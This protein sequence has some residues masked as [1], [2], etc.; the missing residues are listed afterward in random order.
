VG[1]GTDVLAVHNLAD[2]RA[3][4]RVAAP[5]EGPWRCVWSDAATYHDGG[6]DLGHLTVELPPYGY[7]WWTTR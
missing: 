6:L 5:A 3:S 2:A 1:H 7:A 4:V